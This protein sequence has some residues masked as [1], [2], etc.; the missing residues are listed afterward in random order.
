MPLLPNYSDSCRK[1]VRHFCPAG[2]SS[3]ATAS[4]GLLMEECFVGFEQRVAVQ[5]TEQAFAFETLLDRLFLAQ[6]VQHQASN[7]GQIIGPVAD[8]LTS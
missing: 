5:C 3:R 7:G 8:V 1:A 6:H 4:N 2:V